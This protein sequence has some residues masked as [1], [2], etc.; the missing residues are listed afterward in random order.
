[1]PVD[2]PLVTAATAGHTG[3]ESA[4]RALLGHD[5]PDVRAAAFG[6]LARMG[7]L[8]RADLRS[9]LG[10]RSPVVRGRCAAL[11][12]AYP[13][14][15]L[16]ALLH[17]D[18]VGVAERTAWSIGEQGSRSDST[19][20]A[21]ATVA[22]GH[23]DALV[24]ESAVAALG[25]VAATGPVDPSALTAVLGALADDKPA[26]RR[27]AVLALAAFEGAAVRAALRAALDDADWQVRQ[28]A[29]LVID[30]GD[31]AIDG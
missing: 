26:V 9:G 6:A 11:A 13:D 2:D 30:A 4:A 25:A 1:M 8:G 3:D 19:V 23:A 28:G 7:A 14:I 16:T 24:R 10:D 22:R 29:A 5:Q 17:D 31:P 20:D 27:R 21:L 18:D 15:D 12:A